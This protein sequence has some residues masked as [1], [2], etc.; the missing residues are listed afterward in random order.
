MK[1]LCIYVAMHC[2]W[3]KCKYS[4]SSE[5][6]GI[7][8]HDKI[9]S[10]TFPSHVSN[11]LIFPGFPDKWSPCVHR[12]TSLLDLAFR[13]AEV[14]S[15]YRVKPKCEV[16]SLSRP[17]L[18]ISRNISLSPDFLL[19][20]NLGPIVWSKYESRSINKL[21]NGAIL[22]ILKIWKIR[23]I[24]FVGNLMLNIQKKFLDDD[25]IIV[26][27]SVHRTQSIGVLFSPPV[28]T[29]NS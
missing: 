15:K 16:I 11:S 10:L 9:F 7:P 25:V 4:S 6:F 17:N 21:Q 12:L 27:P 5:Q 1:S 28:I 24:R 18:S 29:H 23:N 3:R 13:W 14:L 22:L 20:E 2:F 19:S 26:T 8:F